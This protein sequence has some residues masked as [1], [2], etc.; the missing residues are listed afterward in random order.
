LSQEWHLFLR[1]GG[2]L[3][4]QD[5][6]VI[7]LPVTRAPILQLLHVQKRLY[8]IIEE[9]Y[10]KKNESVSLKLLNIKAEIQRQV[11][12]ALFQI[13]NPSLRQPKRRKV[14]EIEQVI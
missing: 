1:F 5:R 6:Q 12:E 8:S 2:Y 13:N 4:R 14:K 10:D 11:K 9:G 3:G 7:V